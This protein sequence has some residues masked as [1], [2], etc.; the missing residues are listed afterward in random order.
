MTT[1]AWDGR[2]LAA[3]RCSWSNGV[4]R[5][6]RKVFKITR[7]TDGKEIL[8]AFA[9]VQAWAVAVLHWLKDGGEKPRH[10]D[11]GV[12]PDLQCAIVIER[13]GRISMMTNQL[14]YLPVRERKYAFGGGQECAWGALEAGANAKQA[15]RIAMKRTDYAGFGVDSVS[16]T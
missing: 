6:T 1:I 9:G 3:D 15:V 8:I 11:F 5:Q 7:H 14:T 16:F 13:G 10:K 4:R 12:E 2:T